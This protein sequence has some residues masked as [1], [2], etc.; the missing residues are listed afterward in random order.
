MKAFGL[1]SMQSS[2]QSSTQT[3]IQSSVICHLPSIQ[4]SVPS[5]HGRDAVASLPS[6]PRRHELVVE[7][8]EGVGAVGVEE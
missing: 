7:L 4:S 6:L 8:E 3:S 1:L 2:I 5:A